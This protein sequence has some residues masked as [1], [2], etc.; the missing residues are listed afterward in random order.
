MSSMHFHVIGIARTEMRSKFDAPHQPDRRM[1]GGVIELVNGSNFEQALK[2]LE[3]FERIWLLWWFHKN[4]TWHPV[5]L[6]PRGEGIKRGVFATRSPHRPNAIGLTAVPLLGIRGRKLMIGPSDLID[7]TPI[8]D[9]KPYIP[10]IDAF[11]DCR[12]GWVD[13]LE[14]EV[15]NFEVTLS[16]RAEDQQRWLLGMGVNFFERATRILA[17]DP[18]PNRTRRISRFSG[19]FKM[20]CG[21]WRVIFRVKKGRAIVEILEFAPGYPLSSLLD[22]TKE[23]IQDREAQIKFLQKKWRPLA[24]N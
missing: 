21:P 6:P 24:S 12:A 3:G 2:D 9:I 22:I 19:D 1:A 5:V 16:P 8:L 10:E 7:G 4:T 15:T 13:D 11:P 17:S 14:S 20:G 18:S 23:R